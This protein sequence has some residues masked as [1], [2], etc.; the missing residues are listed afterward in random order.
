MCVRILIRVHK[1]HL[2]G[3]KANESPQRL[4]TFSG[5][6]GDEMVESLKRKMLISS[7]KKMD[8]K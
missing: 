2:V 7:I 8:L 3:S 5:G 1:I 4:N 6:G